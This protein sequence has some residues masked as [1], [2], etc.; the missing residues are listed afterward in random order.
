MGRLGRGGSAA[1]GQ[2]IEVN[3]LI[4]R[5]DVVPGF[6]DAGRQSRFVDPAYERWT[7]TRFPRIEDPVP[8]A[9]L[10]RRAGTLNAL[11]TATNTDASSGSRRLTVGGRVGF[12]SSAAEGRGTVA[13]YFGQP[14]PGDTILAGDDH[15]ERITHEAMT[16][17][18]PSAP[19]VLGAGTRG[20]SC[21]AINGTSVAALQALRQVMRA[22]LGLPPED[23]A[24]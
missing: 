14:L 7:E 2:E 5:D 21:V 13:S 4:L 24:P 23:R 6:P 9:S 15:A 20:G 16:D 19:G 22:A 18:S 10:V 8:T 3:A 17:R 11:A 1:V 12:A